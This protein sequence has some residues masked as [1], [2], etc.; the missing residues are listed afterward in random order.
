MSVKVLRKDQ[1]TGSK[2]SAEK[3][4]SVNFTADNKNFCLSLHYN[5]TKSY[6]FVNATE[7]I[8]FK[9]KHSEIVATPLCLGNI[10]KET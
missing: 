3:I 8:E 5:G 4:Y 6:L 9:A 10:S 1:N 2:L 7:I